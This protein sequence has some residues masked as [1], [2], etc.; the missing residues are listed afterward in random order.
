M[1]GSI[2]C[3][4]IVAS[5]VLIVLGTPAWSQDSSRNT[6]IQGVRDSVRHRIQEEHERAAES[7]RSL[8]RPHPQAVSHT[9]CKSGSARR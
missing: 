4:A 2:R 6:I 9:D 7:G 5:G 8:C 1:Q 3:A